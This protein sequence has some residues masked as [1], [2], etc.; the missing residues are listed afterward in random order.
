MRGVTLHI[1]KEINEITLQN[2]QTLT[3]WL[4]KEKIENKPNCHRIN[5]VQVELRVNNGTPEIF[6]DKDKIRLKDWTEWK[7]CKDYVFK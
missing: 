7:P 1:W 4:V 3:V 2:G 5:T 6:A